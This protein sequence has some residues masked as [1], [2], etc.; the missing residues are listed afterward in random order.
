MADNIASNVSRLIER[1]EDFSNM[2]SAANGQLSEDEYFRWV[3]PIS[4]LWETVYDSAQNH[5]GT[6]LSDLIAGRET[7]H[8]RGISVL[9]AVLKTWPFPA[10]AGQITQVCLP[11]Y[12][13]N[14]LRKVFVGMLPQLKVASGLL[15]VEAS[16]S[17][18]LEADYAEPIFKNELAYLFGVERATIARRIATGEL[19]QLPGTPATAKKVRIHGDDFPIGLKRKNERTLR[20]SELKKNGKRQ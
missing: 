17:D 3:V 7:E 4:K 18:F 6:N 8:E 9:T 16:D 11:Q 5:Q 1:I 12:D 15:A 13:Q 20:L 2:K 19:R 14:L 10:I